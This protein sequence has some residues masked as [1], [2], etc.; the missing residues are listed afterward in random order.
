M[1]MISENERFMSKVLSALNDRRDDRKLSEIIFRT[2]DRIKPDT[3]KDKLKTKF[4]VILSMSKAIMDG[5]DSGVELSDEDLDIILKECESRTNAAQIQNIR[6]VAFTHFARDSDIETIIKNCETFNK[7]QIIQSHTNELA[8]LLTSSNSFIELPQHVE[9]F[10]RLTKSIVQK[11]STETVQ[12]DYRELVLLPGKCEPDTPEYVGLRDVHDDVQNESNLVLKTGIAAWDDILT[13]G[14]LHAGKLSIIGS[15]AGG[16]KSITMLDLEVGVMFCRE[17]LKLYSLPQFRGKK[18]VVMAITYENTILQTYRRFMTLLG[19]GS[20]YVNSLTFDELKRDMEEIMSTAPIGIIIKAR[21]AKSESAEDISN[22]IKETEERFNVK[23][24][25]LGHDYIN[26]TVPVN[27]DSANSMGEFM[28][29]GNVAQDIR[30]LICKKLNIHVISAIQLKREWEEKYMDSVKKGDKMPIRCFTGASLFGGN[31][32]KQKADN[33][34][35]VVYGVLNGEPYAEVILDKDRDGN[36]ANKTVSPHAAL[37]TSDVAG[38]FERQNNFVAEVEK[39]NVMLRP[40]Y[41]KDGRLAVA[42]PRNGLALSHDQYYSDRFEISPEA[43]KFMNMFQALDD[44]A[45]E[46]EAS[47]LYQKDE[48][49]EEIEAEVPLNMSEEEALGAVRFKDEQELLKANA[50]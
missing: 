34:Y 32:V 25:L 50:S 21:D 49:V 8:E 22:Y 45:K 39:E 13:G 5:M 33:L 12:K 35:F 38:V 11:M 3:V 15:Y 41:G 36:S 46:V 40:F 17:N 47:K 23:V 24:V 4:N 44:N 48:E 9:K 1:L 26:L 37:R 18:L 2:Y 20:A 10:E 16:G 27:F 14:G 28:D 43:A 29:A 42:I 6:D 30:E 31:I 19:L 7:A